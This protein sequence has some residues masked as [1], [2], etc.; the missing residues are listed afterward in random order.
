MHVVS[1]SSLS[2]AIGTRTRFAAVPVVIGDLVDEIDEGKK[3]VIPSGVT[4][5]WQDKVV[6][7]D[8]NGNLPSSRVNGL[9]D[10]IEHANRYCYCI[11]L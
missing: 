2:S 3:I 1:I 11:G 9:R 7:A 10:F 6:K 5:G 4:R 8:S